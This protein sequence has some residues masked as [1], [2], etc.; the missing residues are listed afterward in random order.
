[1][2]MRLTRRLLVEG[3]LQDKEMLEDVCI[4]DIDADRVQERASATR[5][6]S[7]AENTNW[8][9]WPYR[10][11]GPARSLEIDIRSYEP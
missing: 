9:Y 10:A 8:A 3:A 7:W 5:P 1:M 4:N 11:V 6:T 2:A